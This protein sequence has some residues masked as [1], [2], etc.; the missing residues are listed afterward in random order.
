MKPWFGKKIGEGKEHIVYYSGGKYV[1]KVYV[2]FTKG[3][4]VFKEVWKYITGRNSVPY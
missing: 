2:P 4:K 3:L 1:Y